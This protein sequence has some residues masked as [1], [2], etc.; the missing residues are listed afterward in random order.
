MASSAALRWYK[1]C[2]WTTGVSSGFFVPCLSLL[3]CM[4]LRQ[5]LYLSG[6]FVG[7][8]RL[9]FG[10]LGL[11]FCLWLILELSSPFLDGP[12][13]PD[14][15]F[16]VVWCRF[17]MMRWFLAFFL[18]FLTLLGSTSRLE[19]WLLVLL[20]MG[21]FTCRCRVLVPLVL[22]ETLWSVSGSGLDPLCSRHLASPNVRISKVPFGMPGVPRCPTGFSE[23]E[24][25]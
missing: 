10:L 1:L 20:G 6:V 18:V 9:S 2:S 5:A 14:P 12:L 15:A 8:V 7:F 22:P 11:V 24:F 17:R 3:L 23:W 16:H 19:R 25:P 21:L 13:G 4:V